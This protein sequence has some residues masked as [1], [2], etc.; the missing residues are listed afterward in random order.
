MSL[1]INILAQIDKDKVLMAPNNNKLIFNF[2]KTQAKN[3]MKILSILIRI[4]NLRKIVR[5]VHGARQAY[6]RTGV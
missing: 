2:I 1:K 5:T 6:M 4:K 3:N